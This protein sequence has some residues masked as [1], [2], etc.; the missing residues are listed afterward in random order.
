MMEKS[1]KTRIILLSFLIL[2]VPVFLLTVMTP[3]SASEKVIEWK[4][5]DTYESVPIGQWR[6]VRKCDVIGKDHTVINNKDYYI[7]V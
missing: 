7:C 2:L 6:K 5:Q 1:G 3:A 4:L